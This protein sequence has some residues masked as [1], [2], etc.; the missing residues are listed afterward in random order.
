MRIK[1]KDLLK[2][3]EELEDKIKKNRYNIER[4]MERQELIFDQLIDVYSYEI[5]YCHSQTR[6][7]YMRLLHQ[8][9]NSEEFRE[10]VTKKM[11]AKIMNSLRVF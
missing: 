10:I 9:Q 2:K 3:I 4:N 5:K 11:M 8:L 6:E 7:Y 1:K